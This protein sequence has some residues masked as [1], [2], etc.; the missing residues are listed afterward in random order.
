MIA[1]QSSDKLLP[2]DLNG[3]LKRLCLRLETAQGQLRSAGLFYAK[4]E[5][6]YR[7]AKAFAYLDS[8]GTVEARKALVDKACGEERQT[9]YLAR[10]AK[11]AALENVRS[12][13]AQLSALQSIAASVRS[14]MELASAPQPR[15]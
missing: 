3:K 6:A 5:S 12:I 2:D 15:W 10:A 13:R 8:A 1:R 7:K 11:E 14:E 4:K 9:A